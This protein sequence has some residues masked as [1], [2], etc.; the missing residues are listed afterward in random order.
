MYNSHIEFM[1]EL[2][3]MKNVDPIEEKW[4]WEITSDR[5]VLS[6]INSVSIVIAGHNS[7]GSWNSTLSTSC[8]SY[9]SRYFISSYAPVI[10]ASPGSSVI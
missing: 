10:I 8:P 5:L 6:A 7:L 2:G 4:A 1:S 9:P 3:K